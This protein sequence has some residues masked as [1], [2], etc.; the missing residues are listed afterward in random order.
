ME[1]PEQYYLI[2]SSL[3]NGEVFMGLPREESLPAACITAL[4]FM[5]GH[6]MV[7]LAF[8]IVCLFL[9]R[10]IKGQ[11]GMNVFSCCRYYYTTTPKHASSFKRLPAASLRYWFA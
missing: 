1:Q 7:G 4:G 8:A 2:P 6:E 11:Y 5:V 3:D 10:Y 9:V